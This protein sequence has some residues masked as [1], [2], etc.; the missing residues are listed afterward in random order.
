MVLPGS[1]K[2]SVLP[3]AKV[4]PGKDS[5]LRKCS[6]LILRMVGQGGSGVLF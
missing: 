1:V 6:L 4:N 5:K 2:T 3:M